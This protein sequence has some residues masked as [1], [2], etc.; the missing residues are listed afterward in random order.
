MTKP[1]VRLVFLVLTYFVLN[2]LE[3]SRPYEEHVRKDLQS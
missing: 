2:V 3:A 1:E